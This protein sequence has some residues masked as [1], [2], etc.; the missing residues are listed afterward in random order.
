MDRLSEA[1]GEQGRRQAVAA[2]GSAIVLLEDT[3]L[4][5]DLNEH[6]QALLREL[7]KEELQNILIRERDASGGD[8]AGSVA[9][10]TTVLVLDTSSSMQ[11]G[12]GA[13]LPRTKL[14]A[15]SAGAGTVLSLIRQEHEAKQSVQSAG[16][17]VFNDHIVTSLAPTSDFDSLTRALDSQSPRGGT[18]IYGA[19]NAAVTLLEP[20][21]PNVRRSIILLTD[22]KQETPPRPDADFFVAGGPVERAK[23]A[24]VEICTI[25]FGP[26]GAFNQDLLERMAGETGCEYH[27]AGSEAQLQERFLRLRH[28]SSGA[29]K[30][31]F[32]G[33]VAQNETVTAGVF[34]ISDADGQIAASAGWPGSTLDLRLVDPKGRIVGGGYPGASIGATAT[35]AN[36]VIDRPARG[37]WTMQVYGRDVSMPREPYYAIVSTRPATTARSGGTGGPAAASILLGLGMSALALGTVVMAMRRTSSPDVASLTLTG[38][39]GVQAPLHRGV[40]LVGRDSDCDI[41]LEDD[42]VS[43]RHAYLTVG[44]NGAIVEDLGSTHGTFVNGAGITRASIRSGDV[45][46]VGATD[47]LVR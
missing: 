7:L 36:V 18:D 28:V 43:R 17:I 23:G 47:L 11:E 12:A 10:V 45:L 3:A 8:R 6:D 46:R 15:A 22:G 30:N 4:G 21:A 42:R 14:Q 39:G 35:T 1:P 16:L 38:P 26:P 27:E 25:G 44:H 2:R 37:Q 34:A 33:D 29:I 19:I 13:G 5:P 32:R 31:E 9:G 41:R 40:Y 24:R 20:A